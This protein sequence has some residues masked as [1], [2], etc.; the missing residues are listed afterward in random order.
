MATT[1]DHDAHERSAAG[2]DFEEPIRER[3]ASLGAAM[4]DKGPQALLDEVENL[5][6]EEWRDQIKTFPLTAVLVGVGIGVYL[7]MKRS[8]EIIAAGTTLVSSVAMAN[9]GQVM[10]RVRGGGE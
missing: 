1:R 8:D 6:P 4:A 10:D 7:G 5:L 3:A 2:L 9:V